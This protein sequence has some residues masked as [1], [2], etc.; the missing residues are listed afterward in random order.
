[1]RLVWPVA[2]PDDVR[3]RDAGL[4]ERR[5]RGTVSPGVAECT[6][7]NG[8]QTCGASGTWGPITPCT[9]QTCIVGVCT[10]VCAPNQTQCV[11]N[12]VEECNASGQW[13]TATACAGVCTAGQCSGTCTPPATQCSGYVVETC[14]GGGNWGAPVACVSSTCVSGTCTGVCAPG[15]TECLGNVIQSCGTSGTWQ[16]EATCSGAT[17]ACLNSTCVACSPTTTQCV[18]NSAQTCGA[19]G[20]WQTPVAC[21]NQTCI[22][23]VCTGSCAPART[24]GQRQP[25][26]DVQRRHLAHGEHLLAHDA[27]LLEQRLRRVLAERHAVRGQQRGDV[28]RGRVVGDPRRVH[29][30]DVRERRLH[31]IVRPRP[32]AVQRRQ[33]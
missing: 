12:G 31:R 10:G 5:V 23:G 30:P 8:A 25:D 4:L 2:E 32:D 26:P 28:Q 15:Q 21:T 3:R 13:G 7:T 17:P 9:G 11:G 24:R 18:G 22:S 1:M 6:S 20:S 27:R 14:D 16:T 19:T 33:G 29:Q